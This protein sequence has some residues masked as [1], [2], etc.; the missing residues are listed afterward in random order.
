MLIRFRIRSSTPIAVFTIQD[1]PPINV[2]ASIKHIKMH[3]NEA[4]DVE[5]LERLK[6]K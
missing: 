3:T 1:I 2:F 5:W 4:G 6:V